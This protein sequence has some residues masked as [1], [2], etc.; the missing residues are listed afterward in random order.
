MNLGEN[1]MVSVKPLCSLP[2]VGIVN[3]Q[4]TKLSRLTMNFI[5]LIWHTM[6]ILFK[7]FL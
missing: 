1:F 2:P 4:M 7:D 5:L 3:I 6:M